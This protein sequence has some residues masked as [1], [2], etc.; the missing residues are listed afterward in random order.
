MALKEYEVLIPVKGEISVI[1]NARSEK[2]AVRLVI[3]EE[4]DW[5]EDGTPS[6]DWE[7]DGP[8]AVEAVEMW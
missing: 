2:E 8:G 7:I 6:V 1:V 4:I 5:R 3:E